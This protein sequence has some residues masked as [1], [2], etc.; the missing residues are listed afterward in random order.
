MRSSKQT[1]LDRLFPMGH[2]ITE[3]GLVLHGWGRTKKGKAHVIGT[4]DHAAIDTRIALA[5]SEAV[6]KAVAA[7]GPDPRPIVFIADTQGQALSRREELLGL[8]GYFAHLAR[9]VNLARQQGHRLVTLID[10]EAV[11]GGFL[12]FGL[13]ADCIVA[14]PGAEV[15]VMDLRAMSRITRIPFERL[16]ELART[17]PVFAPGA[18]NY[19]RMG[20]IHALWT[21]ADD[22]SEQLLSLLQGNPEDERARLGVERG[23][24]MLAATVA[25]QVLHAH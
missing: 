20:G 9:C 4:T 7:E 5:L 14:L 23:G 15:R 10:G 8:H 2:D 25:Q 12:A 19:W 24:R 18:Q 13:L 17:S 21:D 1:L 11:S 22:W 6:L 3:A 16:T